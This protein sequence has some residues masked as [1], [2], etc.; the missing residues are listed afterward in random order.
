MH[1]DH[2]M[3]Q[4][5][6]YEKYIKRT[7]DFCG[8]C[9]AIAVTAVPMAATAIAVRIELGSPVLYAA[10]R[11]GLGEKTFKMYKFRSMTNEKDADGNLLPDAMRMT[12]LGKFIRSTSLDELP[13]LFSILK[14]DM[15]FIGPRPLPVEYLPYISEEESIRHSCRGGMSGLAQVSGRTSI[16]WDRKFAYDIEYVNNMS[17]AQDV[18]IFFLT[19]WKVLGRKDV[20]EPEEGANLSL[21]ETRGV[22]RPELLS[23]GSTG[24]K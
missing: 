21:H 20:G 24:R 7:I 12:G 4:Q 9:A 14:G 2:G 5:T 22:K 16:T 10:R 19:I 3:R 11:A 8:A 18:K 17:F 6:V 13:E 1:E 15:A 23:K